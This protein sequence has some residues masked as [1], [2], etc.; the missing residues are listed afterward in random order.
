MKMVLKL[1]SYFT[2]DC[3][4]HYFVRSPVPHFL[5]NF[6]KLLVFS[7]VIRRLPN[8]IWLC[9][10]HEY[11]IHI[12]IGLLCWFVA[13][14]RRWKFGGWSLRFGR[15]TLKRSCG[16]GRNI[17]IT[18]CCC[19]CLVQALVDI[20]LRKYSHGFHWNTFIDLVWVLYSTIQQELFSDNCKLFS[21]AAP[22]EFV[23]LL[24]TVNIQTCFSSSTLLSTVTA[25]FP[26]K[27]F[28]MNAR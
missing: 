17:Y 10:I 18:H 7:M 20:L 4:P 1:A 12:F 27:W 6:F 24:A 26:K 19:V 8:C 25:S 22:R 11:F 9:H 28:I 16:H 3:F 23:I 2:C 15:Q 13:A 21:Y 14:I 5:L